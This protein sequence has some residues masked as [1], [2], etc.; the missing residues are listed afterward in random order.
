LVPNRS[1]GLRPRK[2]DGCCCTRWDVSD[3]EQTGDGAVHIVEDL[4]MD[5][6]SIRQRSGER[7]PDKIQ[8][9]R[10]KLNR[11]QKTKNRL[12]NQKKK[13]NK[14]EQGKPWITRRACSWENNRGLRFV[15]RRLLGRST[16]AP[17]AFPENSIFRTRFVQ[18]GECKSEKTRPT[19]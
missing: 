4:A 8:N 10:E 3:F 6:I 5:G 13:K 12:N 2:D 11:K 9:T 14:K 16:G 17:A 19:K 18:P 7:F 15:S 1:A